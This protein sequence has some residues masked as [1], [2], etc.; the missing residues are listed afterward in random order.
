MDQLLN[1][2]IRFEPETEN[3]NK[4]ERK[5][6]IGGDKWNE[7]ERKRNKWTKKKNLT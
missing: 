2:W 3:N 1:S 4:S 6:G 5:L 7:W